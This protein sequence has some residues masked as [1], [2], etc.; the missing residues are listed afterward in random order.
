M[1]ERSATSGGNPIRRVA[2]LV[3]A[4]LGLF[5]RWNA[6][7]DDWL[8][9]DHEPKSERPIQLGLSGAADKYATEDANADR[10]S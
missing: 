4:L 9:L 3:V 2:D 5:L 8:D 6:D 10:D 7:V 1:C